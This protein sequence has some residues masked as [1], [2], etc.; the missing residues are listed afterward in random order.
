MSTKLTCNTIKLMVW[1]FIFFFNRII[2][3]TIKFFYPCTF[4]HLK[5]LC[6]NFRKLF[7]WIFSCTFSIN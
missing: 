6:N 7:V 4:K 3:C 1:W 5:S 2:F